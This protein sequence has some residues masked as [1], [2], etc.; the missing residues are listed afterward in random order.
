[1]SKLPV[2]MLALDTLVNA[3]Y[4]RYRYKLHVYSI[5]TLVLYMVCML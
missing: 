1:M 5:S 3:Y 2:D 4:S